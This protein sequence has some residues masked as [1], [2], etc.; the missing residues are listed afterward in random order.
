M[1]Y[2]STENSIRNGIFIFKTK[3]MILFWSAKSLSFTSIIFSNT[4]FIA[5]K[6][7]YDKNTKIILPLFS[8]LEMTRE[9]DL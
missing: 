1:S 7:G 9:N 8:I 2:Q 3:L 6:N 4:L 5:L